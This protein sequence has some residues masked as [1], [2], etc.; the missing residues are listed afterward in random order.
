M[1]NDESLVILKEIRSLQ[2]EQVASMNAMLQAQQEYLTLYRSHLE[3]V[4]AINKQAERI[5][6]KGESM[7]DVWKRGVGF[8]LLIVILLVAYLSWILFFR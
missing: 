3:R 2:E 4:E 6:S 8:V 5:Q 7:M 1:Q